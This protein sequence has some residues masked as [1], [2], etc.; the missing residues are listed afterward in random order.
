MSNPVRRQI[1][2][3]LKS[4]LAVPGDP[5]PEPPPLPM[6]PMTDQ[7]RVD[8]LSELMTAIRTEVHQTAAADW[9][10][11]LQ[12]VLSEKG[13][14]EL[15][16]GPQSELGPTIAAAWE[17]STQET[18][19]ALVPYDDNIE[20]FKDRLFEIDAGITATVGAVADLGAVILWPDTAEP[21]LLSLVP[22]VH[23]AVLKASTIYETLDQVI[24]RQRW[25]QG[26]PTN[27]LLISGPS[28]TADIEF[29]LVFGVHGPKEMVMI[30]I[31]DQ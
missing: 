31:T 12:Q 14:K 30:I 6:P 13:I 8:R 4:A 27:A 20:A 26:M 15:A 17:E 10:S 24:E 9:P 23:I 29:K 18:L 5:A 3:A 11:V 16:Y 28:K 1:F 2:D 22:A 19:P 25:S 7:Q 21:R